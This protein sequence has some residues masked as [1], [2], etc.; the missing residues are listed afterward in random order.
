M[1]SGPCDGVT[2]FGDNQMSLLDMQQEMSLASLADLDNAQSIP[3]H[4][5]SIRLPQCFWNDGAKLNGAIAVCACVPHASMCAT[6]TLSASNVLIGTAIT[7]LEDIDFVAVLGRR[8]ALG[9]ACYSC[10]MT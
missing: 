5:R 10:R 2:D 8:A 3:D 7:N 4:W 6:A 1:I 9:H